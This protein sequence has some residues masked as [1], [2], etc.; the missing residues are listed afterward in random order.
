MAYTIPASSIVFMGISALAAIAIP[1]VLYLYFRK[2][3]HADRL[4]FWIGCIVF[5]V[6]ALGLEQAAYLL[7]M[8]WS[9]WQNVQNNLWLYAA[10]GGLFAGVFEETGRLAAF[11]TVLRKK[12]GNDANAL[13][14]GAGHGGIEAVLVLSLSMISNLV[15]SLMVN[16]GT[17]APAMVSAAATLAQTAP[18]MFLVGALERIGAVALHLSLSVLVWFAIKNKKSFALYPLAVLLHAL[19]DFA[20]VAMSQSGV[21][22]W[23]IEGAVFLLA[24]GCAAL[25]VLIWKRNKHREAFVG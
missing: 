10:A 12:R 17:A 22:V 11:A 16:A 6:F 7:I 5:P 13:M 15:F 3:L 1:L 20:A 19:V 8:K 25:A 18:W 14:Y 24:G 9:G 4:P 2:K 21:N 23:L